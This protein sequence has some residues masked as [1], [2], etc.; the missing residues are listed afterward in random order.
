M[1][2]KSQ[3]TT[4]NIDSFKNNLV[5]IPITQTILPDPHPHTFPIQHVRNYIQRSPYGLE[6]YFGGWWCKSGPLIHLLSA[7]PPCHIFGLFTNGLGHWLSRFRW[8][9]T[10]IRTSPNYCPN[11]DPPQ[12]SQLYTRPSILATHY[13]CNCLYLHPSNSL[14]TSF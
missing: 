3:D 14:V 11:C 9:L 10:L 1:M 4:R 6:S 12:E 7:R 5:I 8:N 2:T 13:S